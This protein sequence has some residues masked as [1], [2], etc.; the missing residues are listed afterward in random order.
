ME[1]ME[2]DPQPPAPARETALIT[3]TPSYRPNEQGG[4]EINKQT[5]EKQ[6][7]K[8]T[9]THL[10][11]SPRLSTAPTSK[12]Q[13]KKRKASKQSGKNS[14]RKESVLPL[15]KPNRENRKTIKIV[16]QLPTEVDPQKGNNQCN[17][18]HNDL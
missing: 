1:N 16:E 17:M 2:N 13:E 10:N 7:K 18:Q 9:Q 14:R 8:L 12:A 6:K 3:D 5:K 4:E 15:E 11:F